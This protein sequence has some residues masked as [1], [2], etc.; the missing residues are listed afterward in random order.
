MALVSAIFRQKVSAH[1]FRHRPIKFHICKFRHFKQLS[2]STQLKKTY[3]EA[4][5][6][7]ST[8]F[9]FLIKLAPLALLIE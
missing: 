9:H 3:S 5:Q 1:I 8:I 2:F 4:F 6:L 7:I